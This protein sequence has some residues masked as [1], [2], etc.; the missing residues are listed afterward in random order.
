[1]VVVR[2]AYFA[3]VQYNVWLVIRLI[4]EYEVNL[5]NHT[6]VWIQLHAI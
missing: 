5:I 4:G 2:I 1:M 6:I 3:R